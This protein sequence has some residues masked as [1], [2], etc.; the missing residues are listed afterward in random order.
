ML[1]F[2]PNLLLSLGL[3]NF[4]ARSISLMVVM[5]AGQTVLVFDFTLGSAVSAAD[6]IAPSCAVSLRWRFLRNGAH[7]SQ[8]LR[9]NQVDRRLPIA[10]PADL[11]GTPPPRL[12]RRRRR[13]TGAK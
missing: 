8:Y 10:N 5:T 7:G 3:Y 4:L 1:A 9:P 13:Q 12:E 11:R 6:W 2:A